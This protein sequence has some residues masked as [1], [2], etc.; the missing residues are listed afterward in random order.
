VLF[1]LCWTGTCSL[2]VFGALRIS[3]LLRVS[4]EVEEEGM[5]ASEL[6]VSMTELSVGAAVENALKA[7]KKR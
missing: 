2:V 4:A 1:V 6:G 5:D 7:P 3:G